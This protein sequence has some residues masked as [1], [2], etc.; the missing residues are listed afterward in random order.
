MSVDNISRRSSNLVSNIFHRIP[1]L[2]NGSILGAPCVTQSDQGTEN[3][4]VAYAHTHIWHSLYPMLAGS[5]QH[6]WK[7]GHTNIKP[8]QMWA[9]FCKTWVPGFEKL[10]D[11]GIHRQWYNIVN[12]TD[13]CVTVLHVIAKYLRIILP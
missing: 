4:R 6:Q 9:R 11:K 8:E 2:S 5:I 10:L 3:F 7:C 1:C 12:I 13:R